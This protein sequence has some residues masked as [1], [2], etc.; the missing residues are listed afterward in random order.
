METVLWGGLT[1]LNI[2]H[3]AAVLGSIV[4]ILKYA[5]RVWGWGGRVVGKFNWLMNFETEYNLIYEKLE[6]I[7]FKLEK[8]GG[9]HMPDALERIEQQISFI[10]ARDQ[11]SLHTNPKPIFET[12]ASGE[13]TSVNLA[14]K[15]LLGVG[16]E[17]VKGMGWVNV[18]DPVQREDVVDAWFRA[19]RGKRE[20]NEYVN[21]ID[22][23]GESVRM[24]VVGHPILGGDELLGHLGE[25]TL[26]GAP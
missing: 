2:I 24:H 21:V 9:S 14:Y 4:L 18:I 22:R 10:R 15:K 19:V 25:L 23:N 7:A 6:A 8:N 12:D 26:E 5:K 11:V 1:A 20:F 13:V 16:T 3:I 17:N